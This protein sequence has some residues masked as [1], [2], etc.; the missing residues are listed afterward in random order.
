[1]WGL[2]RFIL[3]TPLQH[4]EAGLELGQ[5]RPRMGRQEG[6]DGSRQDSDVINREAV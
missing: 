5:I 4:S 1:M 2:G 3:L 6:A